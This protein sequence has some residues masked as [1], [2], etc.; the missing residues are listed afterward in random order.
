MTG[1]SI[2]GVSIQSLQDNYPDHSDTAKVVTDTLGEGHW[3]LDSDD[4]NTCAIRLSQA[5]NYGGAPIKAMAGIH[6]EKGPDKNRYMIRA[7]DFVKY[8]KAQFGEPD[9][10]KKASNAAD[11]TAAITGKPGVLFFRLMKDLGGGRSVKRHLYGHADIW[12]GSSVW[13]NDVL[14]KTWEVTLWRV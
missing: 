9:V 7:N 4:L 8:C 1:M 5:F 2:P 11:L 6:L 14:F 13:Y 3:L 12:D 10:T